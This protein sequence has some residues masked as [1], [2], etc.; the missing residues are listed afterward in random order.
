[1]AASP[2][3]E[4]RLAVSLANIIFPGMEANIVDP[5][6]P[7]PVGGIV[8][9]ARRKMVMLGEVRE[10]MLGEED[11]GLLIARHLDVHPNWDISKALKRSQRLQELSLFPELFVAQ[12]GLADIRIKTYDS[13]TAHPSIAIE[14]PHRD[15]VNGGSTMLPLEEDDFLNLFTQRR[16][17]L[18]VFKGASLSEENAL[19]IDKRNKGVDQGMILFFHPEENPSGINSKYGLT[20]FLR[21]LNGE[22]M[23]H[24]G[25]AIQDKAI[26]A[27]KRRVDR[28]ELVFGN[29]PVRKE[30]FTAMVIAHARISYKTGDPRSQNFLESHLYPSPATRL[31][32]Y[33]TNRSPFK[34][35]NEPLDQ[36][37][38][39]NPGNPFTREN[40][41]FVSKLERYQQERIQNERAEADLQVLLS[42]LKTEQ[43]RQLRINVGNDHGSDNGKMRDFLRNLA[44]MAQRTENLD[45][46][47]D[48]L[49]L[50]EEASETGFALQWMNGSVG[51]DHIG[52]Y[53]Q[54]KPG[55]FDRTNPY[56]HSGL[57]LITGLST[58]VSGKKNTL[59]ISSE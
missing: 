31:F 33:V 21:R 18:L 42:S 29:S 27:L 38:I 28:K 25:N 35:P 58:T 36:L 20:E 55:S 7:K 8:Y 30:L 37:I 4:G 48:V 12:V 51:G 5:V 23:D 2:E 54:G 17:G 59:I 44:Y 39:G 10:E 1:M 45:R 53:F 40:Q 6:M 15:P 52:I 13:A 16:G 57:E 47:N 14:I 22:F 32:T 43:A 34:D 26:E 3:P 46:L 41:Q 24:A 56:S 19:V 50:L 9:D 11:K 49:L